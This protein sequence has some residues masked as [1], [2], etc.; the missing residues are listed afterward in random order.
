MFCEGKALLEHE[1][2][3]ICSGLIRAAK[4][5]FSSEVIGIDSLR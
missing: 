4:A 2:R 1:A 5:E 3:W